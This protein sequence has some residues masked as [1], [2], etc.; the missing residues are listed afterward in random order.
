MI[1]SFRLK[2]IFLSKHCK[3]FFENII[4]F[5]YWNYNFKTKTNNFNLKANEYCNWVKSVTNISEWE[6]WIKGSMISLTQKFEFEVS[7]Y[8]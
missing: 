5:S 6:N 4:D 3:Q 2:S 7:E 8:G 1:D